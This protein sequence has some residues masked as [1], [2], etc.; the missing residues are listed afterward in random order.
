MY[1]SSPTN[2]PMPCHKCVNSI[3]SP[4]TWCHSVEVCRIGIWHFALCF[5]LMFSFSYISTILFQ[6]SF[7]CLHSSQFNGAASSFNS[8][9]WI[10]FMTIFF[11]SNL[12]FKNLFS[13]L[14][15]ALRN[16]LNLVH[17]FA[18][19]SKTIVGWD[20]LSFII[21]TTSDYLSHHFSNR[22]IHLILSLLS[23]EH[24]HIGTW[25]E[26]GLGIAWTQDLGNLV[27]QSSITKH[28]I[29]SG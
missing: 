12:S 20:Q 21:F 13:H 24:R 15:K 7:K 25:F 26:V 8:N 17:K 19:A 18:A 3:L 2:F 11:W 27:S 9:V 6:S 23:P 28:P 1:L 22:K 4:P 10:W 29:K 16:L 5:L 14:S